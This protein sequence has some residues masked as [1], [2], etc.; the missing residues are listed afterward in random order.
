MTYTPSTETVRAQYEINGNPEAFDRWHQ[1]E[2]RQAKE[3]A[4]EEGHEAFEE[5]WRH[6][7][8]FPYDHTTD[9]PHRSQP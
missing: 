6:D 9:N 3:E 4:W 8:L 7:H 5:A 2:L 1:E